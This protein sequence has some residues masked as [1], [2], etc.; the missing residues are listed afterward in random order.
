MTQTLNSTSERT[1]GAMVE[2]SQRW[3]RVKVGGETVADSRR[4]LLL[5]EYAFGGKGSRPRL[6]TYYLPPADVRRDR[7]EPAPDN[8]PDA[9]FA[10]FTLRGD[11]ETLA[12][13]AWTF[14]NPPPELAQLQGYFSFSWDQPA[15]W[16]EEEEQVIAHARD[17][18]HRVDV[19][20][21]SRHVRVVIG[22]ETV[23]ETRRPHL[24][25]ETG[26]P[27]RYYIPRADVRQELLEP[28]DSHT[29]CPYK[30]V[31]SY[32]SVRAGDQLAKNVIWYYPN[33]LPES[34]RIRDMLCFYNERV[35]IYVD[36]ALEAKPKTPWS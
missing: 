21:S 11:G 29:Q 15:A 32:Y 7:L 30:G 12:R 16:F 23:A 24:L 35:D 18:H 20:P 25:F 3:L 28:S 17:P 22:G 34:V 4:A 33:P 31:A 9:E 10:Y 13:G 26:L 36:G 1:R 27:V 2:P 19:L 8:T 5:I 14:Q 6:P